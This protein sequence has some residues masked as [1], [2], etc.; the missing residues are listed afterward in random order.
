MRLLVVCRGSDGNAGDEKKR[1]G[2]HSV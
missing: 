1:N 2:M